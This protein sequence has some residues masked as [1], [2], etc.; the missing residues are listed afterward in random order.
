MATRN[1]ALDAASE[2]M[3]VAQARGGD[4]TAQRRLVELHQ[5]R[6][7]RYLLG[8]AITAAEAEEL[9]QDVLLEA[10]RSL[11]SFQGGSRYL[12][13][14]TGIALHRV[15]NYVTRSAWRGVE[16]PLRPDHAVDAASLYDRSPM[17]PERAAAYGEAF[18]ALMRCIELLPR[19][20]RDSLLRIGIEEMTWEEAAAC[21]GEPL[22]SLKSRVSRA[23]KAVRQRLGPSHFETLAAGV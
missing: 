14:L 22:G 12:S 9:T 13:W 4:A 6:L 17:S 16:V 21:T 18:H 23:R 11:A 3:L 8:H 7:H 20:A 19:D 2:A 15:R 1:H 5:A 10:F